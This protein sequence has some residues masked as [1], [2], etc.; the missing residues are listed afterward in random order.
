MSPTLAGLQCAHVCTPTCLWSL[1]VN[2]KFN[3]CDTDIYTNNTYR[4]FTC[5]S[6]IIVMSMVDLFR[7]PVTVTMWMKIRTGSWSVSTY[8][9]RANSCVDKP[10]HLQ[11]IEG[12]RDSN[13]VVCMCKSCHSEMAA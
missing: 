9:M 12:G 5:I 13:F 6:V 10:D 1:T 11:N 2:P 4:I 8:C 7:K 3:L